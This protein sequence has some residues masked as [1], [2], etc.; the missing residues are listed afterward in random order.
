PRRQMGATA[1]AAGGLDREGC[2]RRCDCRRVRRT[3][4]ALLFVSRLYVAIRDV[5]GWPASAVLREATP[6]RRLIAPRAET[7][8]TDHLAFRRPRPVRHGHDPRHHRPA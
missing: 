7:A 6:T 8:D 4:R 3:R 2:A 5:V 1:S